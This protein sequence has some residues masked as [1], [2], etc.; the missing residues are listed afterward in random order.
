MTT[1]LAIA[2]VLG[3]G[4]LALVIGYAMAMGERANHADDKHSGWEER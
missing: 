1:F 2:V 3:A 4:A